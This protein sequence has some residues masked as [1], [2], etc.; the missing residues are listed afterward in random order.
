[1]SVE[2]HHLGHQTR[3][4]LSDETGLSS[5]LIYT[6]DPDEPAMWKI[7]RP[8]PGG[9][10]DLYST[11]R[12]PEPDAKRLRDWLSPVIGSDHAA[13]LVRAVDAAPPP[14]AA[15]KSRS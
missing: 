1:M 10:L 13:E 4:D 11:E 9:Q 3:Y 6:E 7:L 2:R 8:G 14:P 15:W 5:V 12:F